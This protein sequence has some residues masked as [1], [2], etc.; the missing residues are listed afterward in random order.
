MHVTN[1]QFSDKFNNGW[2]KNGWFLA[3]FSNLRQYFEFVGVITWKVF[4]VSF[5]NVLCI[6]PRIY[7]ILDVTNDQFSDKFNYSWNK[8]NKK[9]Q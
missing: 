6:S 4:H 9:N 8:S 7:Y 5:R 3:I 2:I 1:K